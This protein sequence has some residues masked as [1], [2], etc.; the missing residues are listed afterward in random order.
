MVA[1]KRISLLVFGADHNNDLLEA[2]ADNANRGTYYFVESFENA[3]L[4]YGEVIHDHLYEFA[5]E[6]TITVQNGENI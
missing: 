3:G 2:L 4:A 6:I 1:L 5:R